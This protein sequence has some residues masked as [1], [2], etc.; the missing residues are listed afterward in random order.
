MLGQG[1]Q[2]GVAPSGGLHRVVLK[3][4]RS[5]IEVSPNA[6]S[7]TAYWDFVQKG[8]QYIKGISHSG[9]VGEVQGAEGP[10]FSIVVLKVTQ[11]PR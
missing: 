10:M 7:A 1:L 2:D 8:F 6:N 9:L 4:V 11:E 5:F 3:E